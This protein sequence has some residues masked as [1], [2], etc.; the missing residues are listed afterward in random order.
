MDTTASQQNS[1]APLLDLPHSVV[2]EVFSELP[3]LFCLCNEQGQIQFTTQRFL[4]VLGETPALHLDKDKLV[5]LGSFENQQL[6][7]ALLHCCHCSRLNIEERRHVT[8][9]QNKKLLGVFVI[10]SVVGSGQSGK[11]LSLVRLSLPD[12]VDWGRVTEVIDLTARE[13][14]VAQALYQGN[15]LSGLSQSMNLSYNTLKVHMKNILKKFEVN[16]QAELLIKLSM[17]R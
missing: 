17:F 2:E 13:Q 1:F 14:E 11:G 16:S 3:Y 5:L 7:S 9:E 15:K 4:S 10:T 12:T 6:Q 8:I